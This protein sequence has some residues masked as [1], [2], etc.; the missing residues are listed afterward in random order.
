MTKT[1]RENGFRHSWT[2]GSA[3]L[4]VGV[5]LRQT[6]F[7]AAR[8]PIAHVILFPLFPTNPTSVS[9][10]P[11]WGH[12]LMSE[13]IAGQWLWGTSLGPGNMLTP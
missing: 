13:P 1:S 3:F 9:H 5:F 6:C 8:K 10:W 11:E 4:C 2:K 12:M 7:E